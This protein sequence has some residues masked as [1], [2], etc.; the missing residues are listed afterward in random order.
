MR[1]AV[2]D[3]LGARSHVGHQSV[4]ARD[5][6]SVRAS[7]SE[8]ER[9]SENVEECVVKREGGLERVRVCV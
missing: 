4:R 7:E 1:P 6:E 5:V 8:S 9:V 2:S 3:F